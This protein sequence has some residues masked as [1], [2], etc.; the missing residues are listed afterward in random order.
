MVSVNRFLLL[1]VLSVL[2]CATGRAST[3]S[4]KPESISGVMF[5]CA[6]GQIAGLDRDMAAYL[7]ELGVSEQQVVKTE[8]A[9]GTLIYT[10]ATPEAD[11]VTLNLKNR[12]EYRIKDELARL[13]DKDG[14]TREVS[15]ASKK[16][17]LLALM[18]HGRLTN[19]SDMACTLDALREQVGVRQNVVAWT[20]HLSWGWPDGGP[21]RWNTKFWRKGTPLA[22][23]SLDQALLD[24]FL[25]QEQY[26]IGC[27]TASKLSYAHAVLDYYV[28]VKKDAAKAALV[29]ARLLHDME[30]LVGVE[31]AAM[32]DF[33]KGFDQTTRDTPGK[34]LSIKRG[35]AT[36]N[37]VPGDWAYLRNTDPGT[38][39]KT[40]YEGSNAIY[41]GGGR[42]DDYYNDHNHSYS[43]FEK[44]NE[45][46][47]WRNGVFSRRRDGHKVKPLTEE[48]FARLGKT[49]AEGGLVLDYRI[50]PYFFGYEDLPKLPES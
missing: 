20:R 45:V 9:G 11:T 27:Y 5:T 29:R 23:A 24:P 31:P 44:L 7:R 46:Y 22:S 41:L 38:A 16:E 2:Y 30:P 42:F 12:K 37:F 47:Q 33:E 39:E 21:A 10:L 48:D 4:A 26:V 1:L 13:P 40:G 3:T 19:F 18:Q 49:P 17:I 36:G 32:W 15:T 43:Y 8:P 50:A 14:K 28:R 35:V 25:N 6:P 34:I